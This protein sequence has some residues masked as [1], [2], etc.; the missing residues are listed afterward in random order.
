MFSLHIYQITFLPFFRY[1]ESGCY[2]GFMKQRGKNIMAKELQ[3]SAS[4]LLLWNIYTDTDIQ[5]KMEHTQKKALKRASAC[6]G[7]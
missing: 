5:L 3:T 7:I 2:R 6:Q 4:N 1:I